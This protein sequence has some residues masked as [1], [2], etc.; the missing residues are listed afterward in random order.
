[1]EK[2]SDPGKGGESERASGSKPPGGYDRPWLRVEDLLDRL[3]LDEEEDAGFVWE[4]EVE[5]YEAKAKWL[6]IAKVHS[7]RGFS[8]SALYADMRSA[9]NPAKDVAWRKIDDNLFTIQFA[10]LG[11]WNKVMLQ[12]PWM[13]RN[14]AV[15]IE[16]YDGFT[17]PRLVTLD[18]VSVWAQVL[19][20]PDMLLKDHVIR[21]MCRNMGEIKEVQI[22]LPAGYVGE[23]V[24]IHVKLDVAKKLTRFVS[25]TKDRHKEWYQIKYEKLPNFCHKCGHLGHWHEECGDGVHDES[26][27]EW[28]DFILAGGGRGLGRGRGVGRGSEPGRASFGGR[29]R[30]RRN[31]NNPFA[32]VNQTGGSVGGGS[33]AAEG[34]REEFN[35]RKRLSFTDPMIKDGT[36]LLTGSEGKVSDMVGIFDN[37][38]SEEGNKSSGTPGKV[39]APKRTRMD[40]EQHTTNNSGNLLSATSGMEVVREQ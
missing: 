10:C 8:P 23:F 27:F 33:S 13:F 32:W 34:A 16:E 12:G 7:E 15:L 39:Q 3:N 38:N 5:D 9:W 31:E 25:M 11:D 36:L 35:S 20:L 24:R 19:K 4:E 30:G 21:G 17:N 1:L 14:Q 6:A 40:E 28:G 2:D 37:A 26:T 18:R 22:K 29:G